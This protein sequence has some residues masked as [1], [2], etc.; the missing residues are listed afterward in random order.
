M[1]KKNKTPEHALRTVAKLAARKAPAR[2]LYRAM[3]A[4]Y[5]ATGQPVPKDLTSMITKDGVNI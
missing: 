5:R 3:R 2:R 1:G 4:Y